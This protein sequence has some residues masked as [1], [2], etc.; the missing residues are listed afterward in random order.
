MVSAALP[1]FL[2]MQTST[3][4]VLRD[5]ERAFVTLAEVKEW[6]NEGL[7]DLCAR[8]RLKQTRATGTTSSTG[9]ITL[10]DEFLENMSLWIDGA[11]VN[12]VD[13]SVF[14]SYSEPASTTPYALLGRVFDG[15]VETY[16]SQI[17]ADYEW[18]YV[19]R[20]T[21]LSA[22][23]D[24]PSDLTPELARRVIN[25]AR[26]EAKLKE[27]EESEYAIYRGRYEEGLPGQPRV[28]MRMR[29]GPVNLIPES[30]PFG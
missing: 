13:D 24:Q 1:T 23:G 4:A 5:S 6:L 10:P 2:E 18:R 8:L 27:G 15:A 25:F 12:F 21:E 22:D 29:P 17:S 28:A 26:A 30:G 19:K 14:E 3:F 16:P 7:L 20:P 11:P 9:T